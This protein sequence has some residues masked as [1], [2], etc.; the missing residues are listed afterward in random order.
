MII[1]SMKGLGDNIYQRAFIK[2][3]EKELFINTPWPEIYQDLQNVKFTPS[4]TNLRTQSKNIQKQPK[5]IYS[6]PR[7]NHPRK[8]ISYSSEGI[9][10]GMRKSFNFDLTDLDLPDYG[11]SVVHGDYV[12]VR[13]VTV[14]SEW[15]ASARNPNHHYISEAVEHFKDIGYKI[16][17]I[18]DL[19]PKK[20]W[21]IG[22]GVDAD[23]SFNHGEL[24]VTQM[25][26]V[27]DGA[28]FVVGGVG[29]IVPACI[30]YKTPAWIICGGQ[31]GYNSPGHLID[32]NIDF[33]MIG[34]AIPD[35]FCMCKKKEHNCDKTIN[36]H[37]DKLTKWMSG[38][39]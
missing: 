6:K 4:N 39:V 27:I 8:S 5:S 14:R 28:K 11:P 20:E 29:W 24:S 35:K 26:A 25:L 21:L 30:A 15:I 16:V 38:V 10:N 3:I 36:K 22:D 13:P 1:N 18:A 32:D 2:N 9:I 31:G 33:S 37:K 19:E 34:F 7:R 17:S 23:I 12:V